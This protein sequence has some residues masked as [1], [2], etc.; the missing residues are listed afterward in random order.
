MS[1]YIIETRRPATGGR[2]A[3]PWHSD[4]IRG[5]PWLVETEDEA[6]ERF[7]VLLT[8]GPAWDEAEY[9]CREAT[10]RDL[11]L[12]LMARGG[13]YAALAVL[14]DG[15]LDEADRRETEHVAMGD[16]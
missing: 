4:G 9:R 8:V 12:V 5:G 1:T 7:V 3:G 16:R 15:A 10:A 11:V 13:A 14:L 2:E 6:R